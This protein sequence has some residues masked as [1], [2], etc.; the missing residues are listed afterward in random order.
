MSEY[1]YSIACAASYATRIGLPR[2]STLYA[3]LLEVNDTG[4]AIDEI[5]LH[6]THNVN[7]V[8]MNFLLSVRASA[9]LEGH[10]YAIKVSIVS[11][12]GVFTSTPQYYA[13]DPRAPHSE[14]IEIFMP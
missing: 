2:H 12:N 7:S 8:G 14:P 4:E 9:V 1:H 13:V 6:V 3:A 11:D 10:S 5:A